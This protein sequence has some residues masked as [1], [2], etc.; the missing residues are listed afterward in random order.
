VKHS[1][2]EIGKTFWCG[3]RPWRCTD[4]GTRVIVAIRL[5][6]DDD[7]TWYSGPPY[8]VGEISLNEFDLEGC[9][10]EPAPY[11]TDQIKKFVRQRTESSTI[12]YPTDLMRFLD[13][14]AQ[15]DL[16]DGHFRAAAS[17]SVS[18]T[19]ASSKGKKK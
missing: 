7:P 1:D 11:L 3:G 17:I 15:M 6:H 5:D 16:T 18:K 8:A 19:E 4:I 13:F 12:C 14:F 9:S 2:C 10:P